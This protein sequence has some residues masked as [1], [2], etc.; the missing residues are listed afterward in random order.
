MEREFKTCSADIV[1]ALP[2]T[3]SVHQYE[4]VITKEG[5]QNGAF[6]AWSELKRSAWTANNRPVVINHPEGGP[7]TDIETIKGFLSNVKLSEEAREVIATINIFNDNKTIIE[8]IDKGNIKEV[9]I[10][11]WTN[12]EAE[13]GEYEGQTYEVKETG[14]LIDHLALLPDSIGACSVDDGCGVKEPLGV[15]VLNEKKENEKMKEMKHDGALPYRADPTAP[16]DTPWNFKSSDY[17]IDQLAYACAWVADKPADQLTKNDFKLPH[18]TSDGKVVLKGVMAAGN[19]IMGA[20]GGVNIPDGDLPAVKAHLEKHYH[21]FNRSAPWEQKEDEEN[22]KEVEKME[23][24]KIEALEKENEELKKSYEELEIKYN[25]TKKILEEYKERELKVKRNELKE[26][27]EI[28]DEELE[29]ITNVEELDKMIEIA[30][31][32]KANEGEKK[33]VENEKEPEKWWLKYKD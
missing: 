26:I 2:E 31:K 13:K 11:F 20:R 9:S 19:A 18:H 32:I 10:G 24:E 4:A 6:K 22:K 1:K 12:I 15:T 17:T 5:V 28:G 21:Q 25:E 30:K 16:E 23:N 8:D 14:L 27:A 33:V 3:D 29:K 7:V